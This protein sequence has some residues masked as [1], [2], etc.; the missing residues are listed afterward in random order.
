MRSSWIMDGVGQK[1]NEKCPYKTYRGE[2]R[3]RADHMKMKATFGRIQSGAW[4]TWSQQTLKEAQKDSP[5]EP[6]RK[7]LALTLVSAL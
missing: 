5:L 3:D 7:S 4:N 2:F 6:L 1:S